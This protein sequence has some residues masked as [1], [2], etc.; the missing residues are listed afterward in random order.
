MKSK[1]SIY[2]YTMFDPSRCLICLL[3]GEDLL[4]ELL[5]GEE[6][7]NFIKDDHRER[8][9]DDESPVLKVKGRLRRGSVE[10]YRRGS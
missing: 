5:S 2:L 3:L 6:L 1:A 4:L 10:Q 9:E 7:K 8:E